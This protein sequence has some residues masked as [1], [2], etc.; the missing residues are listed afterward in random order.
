MEDCIINS[1]SMQHI[2]LVYIIMTPPPLFPKENGT[3]KA[4]MDS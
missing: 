4:N 3:Y 2:A 1:D